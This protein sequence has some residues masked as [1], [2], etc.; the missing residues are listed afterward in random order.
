MTDDDGEVGASFDR[1]V[2]SLPGRRIRSVDYWDLRAVGREPEWDFGEF[3]LATMGVQ[4]T[5]DTGPVTV[6]WAAT[7]HPYGVDVFPEPIVHH[8]DEDGA[9]R[10]G[11][12]AD[13]PWKALL[14]QPVRAATVSWDRF[15]LGPAMRSNGQVIG[16][17]YEE[18]IPTALRLD[19][20]GGPV[21]FVAG[22][23]RFQEP[24]DLIVPGDDIVVVFA[25]STM[26]QLGYAGGTFAE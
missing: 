16:P 25:A 18:E 26:R 24:F 23:P 19:F 8:L 20:D 5:T 22:T 3:H 1:R 7:F 9:Q 21:W 13:S 6:T 11:P 14:G 12:G 17:P 4:L 2:D 15:T 10:V